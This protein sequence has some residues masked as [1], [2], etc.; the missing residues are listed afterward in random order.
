MREL[1]AAASHLHVD[2]ATAALLVEVAAE[3]RL[4]AS[5]YDED[6]N[7]VFA[8]TDDFDAWTRLPT[9]ERWSRVARAWWGTSRLPGLVGTRDAAGKAHSALAPE[10]TSVFAVDTRRSALVEIAAI[11]D[12]HVLAAGTGPAV[13]RRAA[14]LAASAPPPLPW[15]P[16]GVGPARGDDPGPGRA[17]RHAGVRPG[18]ARRRRPRTPPRAPAPGAG[19]PRAPPGG[20]DRRRPRPARARPGPPVA[21]RGR[22]GVAGRGDRLPV[23]RPV[24][25]S[26][27]R[28]RLDRRRAARVRG[29][30]LPHPGPPAADVP[31]RRHR[32]HLRDRPGRA[33]RGLP[34]RRRRGRAVRAAGAPAGGV[35]RA[36]PDRADRRH[37]HHAPRRAPPP[38]ARDGR[39]AGRGGARRVAARRPARRAAGAHAQGARRRRARDP[40]VGVR[41]PGDRR[42]PGRRPGR[43]RAAGRAS[44]A[45]PP[46]TR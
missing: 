45:S 43:R 17:G 38:A 37:Q 11:P 10:N 42:D 4:L 16:G 26:R 1:K 9:A 2:E 34:P 44:R 36:A 39:G 14:G 30:R 40:R 28:R 6:G 19:G 13:A 3:A 15:R 46:A 18:S 8:P 23:H 41:R 25:T 32:P 5:R 24:R 12:G 31:H 29:R 35:P 33:R 7:A 22:G 27:A 20:P 21:A